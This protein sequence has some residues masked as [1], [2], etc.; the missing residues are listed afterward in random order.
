M[1]FFERYHPERSAD[2]AKRSS[3]KVE[4][5]RARLWWYRLSK[6]F[7]FPLV[8]MRIPFEDC[9]ATIMPAILRLRGRCAS[10]RDHYA[11][12]DHFSNRKSR[13][14]GSALLSS[15]THPATIS[16]TAGPCLNPCPDPPPTIQ[17]F[18]A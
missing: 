8:V 11:Q 12:D 16:P 6:E 14:C 4:G 9:A 13:N 7:S 18:S 5:P 1:N 15:I 3:H 2:F 17:T 10:R